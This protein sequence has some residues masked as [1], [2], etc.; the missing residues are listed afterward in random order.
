MLVIERITL[1]LLLFA[2][3]IQ[4]LIGDTGASI[5]SRISGLIL[6]SVAIDSILTGIKTYF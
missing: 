2:T 3:R 4:K 5:L 6:T 1:V